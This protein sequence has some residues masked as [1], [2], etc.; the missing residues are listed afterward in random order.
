MTAKSA[1]NSANDETLIGKKNKISKS[2]KYSIIC[3]SEEKVS[4]LLKWRKKRFF[5]FASI[6]L[7]ISWNRLPIGSS[8]I[9]YMKINKAVHAVEM[10]GMTIRVYKR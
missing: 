9:Q 5:F 4:Q 8:A 7:S 3:L 10:A 6:K 2:A 1:N